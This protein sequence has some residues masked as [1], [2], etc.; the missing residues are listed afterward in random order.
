MPVGGG[1]GPAQPTPD[2]FASSRSLVRRR[3]QL[4]CSNHLQRGE[5]RLHQ[6]HAESPRPF[7]ASLQV[8]SLFISQR[9][10]SA[11]S[12]FGSISSPDYIRIQLRTT[13]NPSPIQ[14][15]TT[16]PL[17]VSRQMQDS[18]LPSPLGT[19]LLVDVRGAE[20]ISSNSDDPSVLLPHHEEGELQNLWKRWDER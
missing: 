19:Q 18:Q 16:R 2:L 5:A 8:P 11:G 13:P 3:F 10:T 12:S 14:P 17:G 9:F 1:A 15:H 7:P 4:C 20:I 6:H